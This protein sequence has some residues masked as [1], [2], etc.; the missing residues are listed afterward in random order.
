VK[1]APA[2]HQGLILARALGRFGGQRLVRIRGLPV[3][4]MAG[5]VFDSVLC[6]GR[7]PRS[8]SYR[9]EKAYRRLLRVVAI[10]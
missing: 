5:R 6:V 1:A 7:R 10:T 2:G 4:A 3:R 9:P 8:R